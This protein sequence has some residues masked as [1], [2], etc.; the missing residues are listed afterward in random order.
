MIKEIV[1]LLLLLVLHLPIFGIVSSGASIVVSLLLLGCRPST[2]SH[3]L[4]AVVGLSLGLV[5]VGWRRLLWR[6]PHHWI[7]VVLVV[8]FRLTAIATTVAAGRL[9]VALNRGCV[10]PMVGGSRLA[11][12]APL[13][14]VLSVILRVVLVVFKWSVTAKLVDLHMNNLH[15][16]DWGSTWP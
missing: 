9:V 7:L 6:V 15:A 4:L 8:R 14:S 3:L 11:D 5:V 13:E 16:W 10:V 2:S 12:H 1:S